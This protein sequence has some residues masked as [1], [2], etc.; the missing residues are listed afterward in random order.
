MYIAPAFTEG[1]RISGAL[2]ELLGLYIIV[3][4]W[5]EKVLPAWFLFKNYRWLMVIALYWWTLQTIGG[6]GIFALRYLVAAA[7]SSSG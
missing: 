7:G 5:F 1:L 3:R 2:L 4:M 6:V